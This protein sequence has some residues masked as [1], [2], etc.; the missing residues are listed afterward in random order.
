MLNNKSGGTV[1]IMLNERWV[2]Y[3]LQE[4]V[5]VQPIL[6]AT[7]TFRTVK[8]IETG[9]NRASFLD[10][11]INSTLRIYISSICC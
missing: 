11:I 10:T 3:T 5:E 4:Q 1:C 6:L 2:H 9:Q 7:L 8:F